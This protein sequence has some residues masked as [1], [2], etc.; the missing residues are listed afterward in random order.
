MHTMTTVKK[1]SYTEEQITF[2]PIYLWIEDV[3]LF[4]CIVKSKINI[5]DIE[6]TDWFT[7]Q[8][9]QSCVI[10]DKNNLIIIT[11]FVG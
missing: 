6:D 7:N 3:N 11:F 5:H 10:L 2:Q 1:F 8:S 4:L 9:G